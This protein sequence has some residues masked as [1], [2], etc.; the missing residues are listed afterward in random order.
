MEWKTCAFFWGVLY[1]YGILDT[2]M[3]VKGA[4]GNYPDGN[5]AVSKHLQRARK[6][7]NS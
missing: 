1:M 6:I 7:P 3:F 4:S 5:L 2:L